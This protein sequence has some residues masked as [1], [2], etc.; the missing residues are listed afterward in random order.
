MYLTEQQ[1]SV[2]ADASRRYDKNFS[3]CIIIFKI[4]GDTVCDAYLRETGNNN[5]NSNNNTCS[6]DINV[7]ALHIIYDIYIHVYI[8]TRIYL[9]LTDKYYIIL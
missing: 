7:G 8:Y 9:L 5:N 2:I 4:V 1:Y 3:R 6:G